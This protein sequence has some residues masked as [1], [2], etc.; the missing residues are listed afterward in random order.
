MQHLA[1]KGE[2]SDIFLTR[3]NQ[4]PITHVFLGLLQ[5]LLRVD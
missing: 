2:I 1:N 3:C 4:I 5:R